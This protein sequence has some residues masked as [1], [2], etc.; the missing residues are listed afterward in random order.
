MKLELFNNIVKTTKD[1]FVQNFMKELSDFS[2]H[3]DGREESRLSDLDGFREENCLYQVVDR[4]RNGVFI[5][6][7]NNKKVFEETKMSKEI[8]DKISNDYILR[9]KNGEYIIEEELTDE[10]FE[11][12]E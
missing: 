11:N 6:N 1:N 8:L 7:M 12:L 2:E 3:K 4:S 9:Y 10:F 5:Q